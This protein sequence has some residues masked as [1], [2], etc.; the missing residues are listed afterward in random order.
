[1]G[2]PDSHRNTSKRS[3]GV[4][5]SPLCKASSVGSTPFRAMIQL[6]S[7]GSGATKS[8]NEN[9]RQPQEYFEKKLR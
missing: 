5:G 7:R 1:M 9:T 6:V 3:S 2:T 8:R 4:G